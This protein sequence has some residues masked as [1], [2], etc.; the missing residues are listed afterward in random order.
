AADAVHAMQVGDREERVGH[1][2]RH[3]GAIRRHRGRIGDTTANQPDGQTRQEREGEQEA[4]AEQGVCAIHDQYSALCR[5]CPNAE[6]ATSSSPAGR[7]ASL[8]TNEYC[9]AP[10]AKASALAS[11]SSA[12]IEQRRTSIPATSISAWSNRRCANSWNRMRR[13]RTRLGVARKRM[14]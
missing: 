9:I 2:G 14:I 1:Q 5:N 11:S 13:R 12:T 6:G 7:G 4:F 8:S 3:G 10:T